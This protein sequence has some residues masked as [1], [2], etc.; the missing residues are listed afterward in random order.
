MDAGAFSDEKVVAASAPFVRVIVNNTDGD[1]KA[2]L[3]L[4]GVKGYP[5]VL[6]LDPDG[7]EIGR[8]GSRSPYD[9]VEQ[10]ERH[11]AAYRFEPGDIPKGDPRA[12]H[13]ALV[14]ALRAAADDPDPERAV[15]AR[16]LLRY[17][18]DPAGEPAT[19]PWIDERIAGLAHDD[20]DVR[21]R[22]T[23]DLLGLLRRLQR[24]DR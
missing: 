6:F 23:A 15:R 4:Y 16:R 8:L 9:V 2:L 3:A 22:A 19:V 20:P 24:S 13:A 17:A 18:A 5:T 1:K 7:K 21:E 14:A 12:V 10:L 11:A